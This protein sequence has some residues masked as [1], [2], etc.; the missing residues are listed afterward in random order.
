MNYRF[1]KSS[2]CSLIA[3]V[4]I[5]Y[6]VAWAVLRCSHEDDFANA[7][8]AMADASAYS[9]GS[10]YSFQRQD[11]AHLDCMGSDYHTEALAGFSASLEQ[12]VLFTDIASRVTDLSNLHDTGTAESDGNLWLSALF[13][14]LVHSSRIGLP[15]YL[16][17][18]VLRI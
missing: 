16:S 7:A 12:R 2:L 13:D 15:L 14:G 10:S 11:G 9:T 1:A 3:L 18:S 5:Y 4:L 17:I 8:A 6:S